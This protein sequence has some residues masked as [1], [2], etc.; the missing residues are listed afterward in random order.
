V[1]FNFAAFLVRD[2][3]LPDDQA[4]SWLSHWDSGNSPP[5]GED[6]LREIIASAHR[7]GRN[8]Y[9]SGLSTCLNSQ[10]LQIPQ[11]KK[12]PK[13]SSIQRVIQP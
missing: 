6:R 13:V 9:G 4:L 8:A 2:L 11:W 12:L 5:K 1:A 7:Y 3:Q 10:K